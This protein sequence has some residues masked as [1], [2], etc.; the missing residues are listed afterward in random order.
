MRFDLLHCREECSGLVRPGAFQVDTIK[1][2]SQNVEQFLEE[3]GVRDG[4]LQEVFSKMSGIWQQHTGIRRK[5]SSDVIETVLPDQ[6]HIPI[7]TGK[8]SFKKS[9]LI[10]TIFCI[11]SFGF[12][13][14]QL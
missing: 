3:A 12:E 14:C 11:L 13:V 1:M 7:N 8:F 5:L 4:K 9:V 10:P 2:K 6:K